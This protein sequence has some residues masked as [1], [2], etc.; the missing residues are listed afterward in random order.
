M[1]HYNY[2]SVFQAENIKFDDLKKMNDELDVHELLDYNIRYE[3]NFIELK[4]GELFFW[5]R[6]EEEYASSVNVWGC[7]YSAQFDT[8]AKHL[9]DG[10][11]VFLY[12]PEGEMHSY[13]VITPGKYEIKEPVF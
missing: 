4:N 11:I 2:L 7:F 10:K 12:Q 3:G 13:H 6:E 1:S 8:I 9:T 5:D